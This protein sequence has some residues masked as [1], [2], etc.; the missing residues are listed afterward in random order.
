MSS[1]TGTVITAES[2]LSQI[3]EKV[4][5]RVDDAKIVEEI[6]VGAVKYSI[7]RQAVGSDIIF[8]F[9]K[10]ISFEGDSGPY[11]QY[12]TVRA[13]SL[14]VKAEGNV[15]VSENLPDGWQTMNLERL[16]ERF[17]AIVERAGREYSPS[18][19][20][21]YLTELA[22]EFNS[23]YN[24]G[25]II[26]AENAAVSGYKLALTKTFADVM[27]KGLDLLGIKVPEKM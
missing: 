22:G 8:D 13:R 15:E 12:S 23:F 1:R 14:L 26:D 25:K 6:A 24:S 17:P 2:L 5:D 9:D 20:V 16:L 4:K 19:L 10:S 21:T 18:Q 3:K 7:L 11:L 27:E